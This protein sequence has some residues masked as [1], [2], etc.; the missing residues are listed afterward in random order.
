MELIMRLS[1]QMV[2]VLMLSACGPVPERKPRENPSPSRSLTVDISIP[3][4]PQ[5]TEVTA[6]AGYKV[7]DDSCLPMDYTKAVGGVKAPSLY[8]EPIR[9]KN[10]GGDAFQITVYEDFYISEPLYTDDKKCD[11]ELSNVSFNLAKDG[12]RRIAAITDDQIRSGDQK[13]MYC[14]FERKKFSTGICSEE[15]YRTASNE[16]NVLIKRR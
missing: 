12:L 3:K 7:V 13:I 10:I 14:D 2:V 5:A 15:S 4:L 6:I 16:F 9:V 1:I 8:W 11:W